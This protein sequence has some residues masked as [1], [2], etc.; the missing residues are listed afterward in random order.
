MYLP[1]SSPWMTDSS[2]KLRCYIGCNEGIRRR[3]KTQS[4]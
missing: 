2:L 4:R 1:A 3:Q